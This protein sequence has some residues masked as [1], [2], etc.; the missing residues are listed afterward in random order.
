MTET[1]PLLDWMANHPHGATYDE[2]RDGPRL[3]AQCNRVYLV[4]RTGAWH[5]LA[6]LS[7]A[8]GDP[9]ASVSARLRDL[10]KHG[11]VVEREYVQ[12]GLWRYRLKP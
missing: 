10:R 4:M 9:Q 12:R 1:A 6:S 2:A 3:N 8:T 5:T 7:I 11:Y